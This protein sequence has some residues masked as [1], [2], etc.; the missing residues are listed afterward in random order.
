MEL[1]AEEENH[2]SADPVK[3]QISSHWELQELYLYIQHLERLVDQ[4]VYSHLVILAAHRV[5]FHSVGHQR[6]K[7]HLTQKE[8]VAMSWKDGGYLHR[9]WCCGSKTTQICFLNDVKNIKLLPLN[10]TYFKPAVPLYFLL[11][12]ANLTHSFYNQHTHVAQGKRYAHGQYIHFLALKVSA[13][14]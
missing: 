11:P 12:S 3:L 9:S 5:V 4:F 14:F 2:N 13:E 1:E 7:R 6:S 10:F 8:Y